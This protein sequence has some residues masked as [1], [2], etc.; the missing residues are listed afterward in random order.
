MRETPVQTPAAN[1]NIEISLRDVVAPLFRRKRL[2]LTSFLAIFAGIVILAVLRGPSYSSHMAILVSRERLDPLVSTQQTTPLV[3]TDDAVTQEEINSEAELLRSHDVLEKVVVANGLQKH[4]GFSL[5]DLLRPGQTEQ[6]RIERAVKA[7]AENL[8]ITPI[9]ESD[10][11]QVTYGSSNPQLAFAVLKSLGNAYLAKQVAVHRPAGSYKFFATETQKYSD[12]LHAAED[13]LR[14]FEVQNAVADPNDQL[15]N[16]AQQVAASVG[17]LHQ[18][19]EAIAADEQR[20]REDQ[21]EMGNT[22]RRSETQQA[23]S[24]NE[25]LIDDASTDLLAA[26]TKRLQLVLKYVD[27]YP[28]VKEADEEIAQD[29]AAVE[30][31]ERKTYTSQTTNRDPTFELLR[32]DLAKTEADLAAQRATRI[33]A[34]SSIHSIQDQMVTLDQLALSQ[35]DL[36]RDTKVAEGNY[37]LY[38]GKREQERASNAMDVSRIANVAIAVPP[39]IPVLPTHSWPFIVVIGLAIAAFFSVGIGYAADYLDPSFYTPA[40]VSETLGIPVVI[41]MPKWAA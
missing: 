40:Q 32:E 14:R 11:I 37:L 34:R 31:A 19:Q 1:R 3:T 30:R 10:I 26:E 23:T 24:S 39:A 5:S 22:P 41:A 2:I 9:Q 15:S 18:A 16:L 13:N 12:E 8:K 4:R 28:L 35:R 21:I 20:L 17:T 27:N 36:E 38:L 29:R 6:D 33:A 7:L 25:K